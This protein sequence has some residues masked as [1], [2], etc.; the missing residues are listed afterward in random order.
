MGISGPTQT[1]EDLT[2]PLNIVLLYRRNTQPDLQLVDLIERELVSAGN[3]VFVDR[4]MGIGVEWARVIDARIRAADAVIVVVSAAGMASE[5]LQYEVE[6]AADEHRK[7]GH[8]LILPIAVGVALLPSGPVGELLGSLQSATWLGGADDQRALD[9]VRAV[10]AN[11][12]WEKGVDHHLEAAGGAISPDSAFYIVRD[13][14]DGLKRAIDARESTILLRGPRQIGKTSLVA[15]GVRHAK[16]LG[17]HIASTDFQV[18]G[19]AQLSDANLFTRVLAASLAKQ[20]GIAYDFVLPSIVDQ[21]S[22][23]SDQRT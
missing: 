20:L 14:D 21:T 5:M 7:R 6:A 2:R 17:W 4:Q 1:S 8:P 3:H 22:V 13:C 10:L 18:I 23:S 11:A 9:E 15:Q 16:S 19:A 12:S